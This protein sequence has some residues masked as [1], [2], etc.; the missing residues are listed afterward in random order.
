MASLM[1]RPVTLSARDR[2]ELLRLTT[3]GVR[4][5]SS[6][7]RARVLLALDTSA[8]EPEPK[9]AIAARLGVSGEML[10]LIAKRFAETGGDVLAT[11]SRKRRDLPPVP[12]PVTG[13]VEARLIALARSQPPTGMPGG[14]CGCWRCSFLLVPRI[15]VGRE[16]RV[17]VRGTGSARSTSRTPVNA[18]G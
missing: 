2:E 16:P 10:R 8:G 3:T 13:E 6:I 14:R 1:K 15:S 4:P 5:A 12:S 11:I 7:M 17:V 18:P 9:D